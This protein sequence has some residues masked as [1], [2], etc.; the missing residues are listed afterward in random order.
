MSDYTSL[1]GLSNFHE[2]QLLE[3]LGP[4][5]V[6]F[7]DWG[8]TNVGAFNNVKLGNLD[9]NGGDRSALKLSADPNYSTGRV[10]QLPTRNIVWESGV[11]NNSAVNISGIYVN[12]SFLPLNTSGNYAYNIDYKNGRVI[13]NS[14][15]SSSTNVKMEYSHKIIDIKEAR[16]SK[17]MQ[18]MQ[19]D[20]YDTTTTQYSSGSGEASIL[21]PNKIQTPH[22]AIEITPS[23][24]SKP[25]EIG[26]FTEIRDIDILCH[27]FSNDYIY[28]EKIGDILINQKE[29]SF[30]LLD[31]DH[32]A[33]SGD[34]PL[35]YRGYKKSSV[36]NYPVLVDYNNNMYREYQARFKNTYVSSNTYINYNFKDLIGNGLHHLV[37]R[38]TV[39]I[40]KTF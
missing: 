4:N 26:S 2:T 23:I 24:N 40:I 6:M 38:M 27:V 33:R 19:L 34:F 31:L 28:K 10:W 35:D 29:K 7:L 14:G 12:S 11:N 32:I 1:K 36:K 22:I 15:L 3:S 16:E 9:I 30:F 39:E 18:Y 17:L 21:S 25:Y 13:F 8:L 20:G 5:I 37:I